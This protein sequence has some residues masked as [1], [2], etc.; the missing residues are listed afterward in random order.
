MVEIK[1]PLDLPDVRL[2]STEITDSGE[3]VI[4]VESTLEGATCHRCGVRITDFHGHDAP[5]RLRHLSILNSPVWI[6]IRPRRYRPFCRG[7]PTSTQRTVWYEPGV[8]DVPNLALPH[9]L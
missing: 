8:K 9:F 2:L 1:F 3:L 5:I 6:Q 4:S 7:G